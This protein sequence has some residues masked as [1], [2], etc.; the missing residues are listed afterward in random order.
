VNKE[1]A[2]KLLEVEDEIS[3]KQTDKR[4]GLTLLKDDRFAAMFSNPDFQVKLHPP[5]LNILIHLFNNWHICCI[6]I[7]CEQIQEFQNTMECK[8]I[9]IESL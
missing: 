4:A 1:L 8:V 6:M 7:F 3:K 2:E 9:Q 5:L